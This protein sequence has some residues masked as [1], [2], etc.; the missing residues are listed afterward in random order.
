MTA[1]DIDALREEALATPE[2][3]EFSQGYEVLCRGIEF[4]VPPVALWPITFFKCQREGDQFGAAAALVGEETADALAAAGM[5]LDDLQRIATALPRP[6]GL[7]GHN[8]TKPSS[9]PGG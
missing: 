7:S 9:E 5:V 6:E 1:I 8:P 2:G 3:R 4:R